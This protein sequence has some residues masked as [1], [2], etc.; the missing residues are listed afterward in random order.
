M[1]VVFKLFPKDENHHSINTCDISVQNLKYASG[2]F[3]MNLIPNAIIWEFRP[4]DL[5]YE[6]NFG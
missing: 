2:P 5:L 4:L 3:M 6:W 1:N